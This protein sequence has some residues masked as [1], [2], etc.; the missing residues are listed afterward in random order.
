[1]TKDRHETDHIIKNMP[2]TELHLH[3]GPFS[4][5]KEM[6]SR[7]EIKKSLEFDPK[8]DEDILKMVSVDENS[9]NLTDFLSKFR[10]IKNIFTSPEVISD[11]T[12]QIIRNAMEQG[13]IYLELRFSPFFLC[14]NSLFSKRDVVKSVIKAVESCNRSFS[15]D[16]GSPLI[17]GRHIHTETIMILSRHAPVSELYKLLE[18]CSEYFGT[19]IKGID[20][21]GDETHFPPQAFTGLFKDLSSVNDLGLTVHAGEI[22]IPENVDW[23]VEKM[24]AKRIGHGVWSIKSDYTIGLLKERGVL[25]EICPTSNHHTGVVAEIEDHPALKLYEKGVRLSISTD[26]PLISRIDLNSEY[27]VCLEKL[28][29]DFDQLV[30]TN[31]MAVDAAFTDST[32]KALLKRSIEDQAAESGML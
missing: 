18:E 21:A 26:D 2:K 3:L 22:E 14:N 15:P 23:A 13:C 30:K 12:C 11:I 31:L 1:M 27:R 32:T 28:H 20:L 19:G 17:P 4:T 10:P 9:T 29:F 16:K 8:S 24:G 25:L 5:I 7:P 6:F